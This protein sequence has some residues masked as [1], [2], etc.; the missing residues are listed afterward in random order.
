LWVPGRLF[1]A[2]SS[3]ERH[4]RTP[5]S[6]RPC[7]RAERLELDLDRPAHGAPHRQARAD[8]AAHW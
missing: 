1:L 3:A 8:S 5:R 6:G 2:N 7:R 4:R